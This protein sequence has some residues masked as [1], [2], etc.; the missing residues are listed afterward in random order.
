MKPED[1]DFTLPEDLIAQHP[2][3]E[4]DASRLLVL[5]RESGAIAHRDFKDIVEYLCFGDIL[6]LNDTR[7]IPARLTGRKPTGGAVELLLVK[8]LA[9]TGGSGKGEKQ[10]W[11]CMVRSSKGVKEGGCVEFGDKHLKA[12]AVN[13]AKEGLQDFEFATPKARG[14]ADEVQM[15]GKVPLPPYI[16][17]EPVELDRERYQTVFAK[18][19]GAIAAPTAGLHFTEGLL[20]EIRAKG[21]AVRYITLHTGPATFLPVRV[22]DIEEHVV[23]PERF[24]VPGGLCAEIKSAQEAGARVFAVGSTV[25]RALETV[26]SGKCGEQGGTDG[27]IE[28][29]TSI[30]IYP[31]FRFKA[32]DAMVTNFHLPR[33]SLLML[34]AAFGKR[35]NV[36]AAY[37]EAV[38]RR[39]RFFSY[40]DCMLLK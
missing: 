1:F 25:T 5:E 26:F 20:D 29:E 27:D 12:T 7:V 39:Y 35:E 36:L 11:R 28:G 2:L 24:V 23:P 14:F 37:R 17:R 18:R 32:I 19:D 34:V 22:E 4:R 30:F 21:V 8:R 13:S 15:L 40:G 9:S 10:M 6:V 31:G 38:G 33:S 3:K 16:Q